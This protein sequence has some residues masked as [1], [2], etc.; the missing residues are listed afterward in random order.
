MLAGEKAWTLNHFILVTHWLKTMT[1]P[2]RL[3][4]EAYFSF[5]QECPDAGLDSPPPIIQLFSQVISG[6]LHTGSHTDTV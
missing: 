6:I 5:S 4:K 3:R 2:G 1:S